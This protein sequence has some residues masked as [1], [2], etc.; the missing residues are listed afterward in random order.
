MI[1]RDPLKIPCLTEK[2]WATFEQ[3]P[4]RKLARMLQWVR[5]RSDGMP[6]VSSL[7]LADQVALEENNV[8]QSLAYARDHLQL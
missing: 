1:T 6:K 4:G 3:L 2:Y 8:M 7:P 5:S